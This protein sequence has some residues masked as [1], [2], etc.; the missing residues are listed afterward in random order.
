MERSLARGLRMEFLRNVTRFDPE[1]LIILSA[2]KLEPVCISQA[3][4]TTVL[5]LCVAIPL[6]LSHNLLVSFSKVLLQILDEQSAGILAKDRESDQ[7]ILEGREA[8]N[9]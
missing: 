8:Q 2:I 9:A 4:V 3:L 5:G 6:L 7:Y 1:S